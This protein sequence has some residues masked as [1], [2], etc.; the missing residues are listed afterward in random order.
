MKAAHSSSD[1]AS[2]K[3]TSVSAVADIMHTGTWLASTLLCLSLSSP[4]PLLPPPGP[5]NM[6][7]LK[8]AGLMSLPGIGQAAAARSE[9]LT[10]RHLAK[11]TKNCPKCCSAKGGRGGQD[12]GRWGTDFLKQRA[13]LPGRPPESNMPLPKRVPNVCRRPCVKLGQAT[14]CVAFCLPGGGEHKVR[15]QEC[16][17]CFERFNI[18]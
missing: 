9:L 2:P 17:T 6:C 8:A 4:G 18:V 15:N 16:W 5:A 14:F 11:T 13:G 12:G 7:P 1:L 10:L 3:S